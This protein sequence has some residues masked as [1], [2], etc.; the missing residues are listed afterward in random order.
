MRLGI[1]VVYLV[2]EENGPLLDLHLA[3]IERCTSVPYRIYAAPVR[4]AP[5]FRQ[6]L[7]R[8]RPLTLCPLEPTAARGTPEHAHYLDRLVEAAVADGVS[9]VAVLHVDSFPVREGWAE[10]LAA[11]LTDRC[12]VA[13]VCRD[14]MRDLKPCT[15]GMLFERDFYHRYRPRFLLT[16]AERES[17]DYRRYAREVDHVPDSGVGFGLAIHRHG[18]T[19]HPLPKSNRAEDHPRIGAVYG[20]TFFHLGFAARHE[21]ALAGSIAQVARTRPVARALSRRLV[22]ANV[23]RGEASAV[24]SCILG[25]VAA[26]LG[27]PHGLATVGAVRER[28]LAD[29][30]GYVDYLRTG[31]KRGEEG[32]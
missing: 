11:T 15:A 23:W 22:P 13:A 21:Q 28:L 18:L 26:S 24:W 1:A 32:I 25:K 12:V 29:P 9:H 2:E 6:V 7:E 31:K 27:R 4:L 3:R 17:V 16:E 14:E 5:S 19:W 30:D 20:D 8:H 10:E